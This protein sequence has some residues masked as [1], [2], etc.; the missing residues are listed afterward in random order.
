MQIIRI[1]KNSAGATLARL[2]LSPGSHGRVKA[3]FKIEGSMSAFM[4]QREY[5][6]SVDAENAAIDQAKQRR[7]V[8]L[9][10]EDNI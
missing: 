6:S 5:E 9:I 4:E 8:C 2:W 1:P 7:A 3:S 10:I